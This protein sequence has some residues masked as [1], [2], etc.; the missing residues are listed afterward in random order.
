MEASDWSTLRLRLAVYLPAAKPR[1]PTQILNQPPA[2]VGV[3]DF[4]ASMTDVEVF[5]PGSLVGLRAAEEDADYILSAV[6]TSVSEDAAVFRGR[7]V[8]RPNWHMKRGVHAPSDQRTAAL[9]QRR[10]NYTFEY[11]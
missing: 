6:S 9:L 7:S 1:T 2:S 11:F 3:H 10:S 4:Y 8:T 5:D